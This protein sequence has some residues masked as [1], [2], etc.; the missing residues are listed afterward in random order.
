MFALCSSCWI[1]AVCPLTQWERPHDYDGPELSDVT[2][3]ADA[4]AVATGAH[5]L[6]AATGSVLAAQP[7]A[8]SGDSAPASS[9][10]T[11]TFML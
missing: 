4:A 9:T 1:V 6:T 2:Q 10:C 8:A 5:T 7:S 3:A 11:Y